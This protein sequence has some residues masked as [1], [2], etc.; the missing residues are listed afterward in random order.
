MNKTNE[1]NNERPMKKILI[2]E[3]D[4]NIA[5]ALAIRLKSAGYQ[6]TVAAD[7]MSGVAAAL[8]IQPDLALLDISVP[9]G[10][11]FG[12]AERIQL[13]IPTATPLIF[14]T[15]SKQPGLRQKAQD[16]GAAGF[17]EKPY[18]AEDLLTAIRRAFGEVPELSPVGA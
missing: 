7:A 1:T 5:K 11:G 15:A 10:S 16:L 14:L 3:D 6:V 4:Q 2:V 17:F 12:V 9:A 13:L 8:K 18:E